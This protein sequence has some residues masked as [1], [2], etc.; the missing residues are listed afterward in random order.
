MKNKKEIIN[1]FFSA[2]LITA[3]VICS[4]Y[5]SSITA[6]SGSVAAGVIKALIFAVFGLLLFYATRVGDGRQVKRFSLVTLII[7]DIPALYII[8]ASILQGLPFYTQL[9]S[10]PEVMY[11]AGVALGYGI[12]YTFLSGYEIAQDEDSTD[13]P[14]DEDEYGEEPLPLAGGIAEELAKEEPAVNGEET[15]AAV[16]FEEPEDSAEAAEESTPEEDSPEE[17]E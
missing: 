8:L 1:L 11:V 5:F 13:A 6:L 14:A 16:S 15:V 2:F 4:Y 12:P 17:T 3:Y 10:V 7:L 9:S